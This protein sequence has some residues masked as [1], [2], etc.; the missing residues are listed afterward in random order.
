MSE[1]TLWLNN[2]NPIVILESF[3]IIEPVAHVGRKTIKLPK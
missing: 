1:I 3:G 2:S